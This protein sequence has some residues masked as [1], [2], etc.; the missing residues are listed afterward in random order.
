MNILIK[1]GLKNPECIGQGSFG[2]VYSG[3]DQTLGN[4]LICIKIIPFGKFNEKEKV[5]TTLLKDVNCPYLVKFYGCDEITEGNLKYF[6]LKM[7]HVNNGDF[8]KYIDENSIETDQLREFFF[9]ICIFFYFLF[10]L[11]IYF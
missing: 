9:Q 1:L 4:K 11:F 8:K 6:T 3:Y 2:K 10:L 5:A 7:E